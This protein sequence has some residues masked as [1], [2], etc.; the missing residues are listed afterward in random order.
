MRRPLWQNIKTLY[1]I[2]NKGILNTIGTLQVVSL[3]LKYKSQQ[4]TLCIVITEHTLSGIF[5][6]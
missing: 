2:L 1:Y 6:L 4:E 5:G 3:L